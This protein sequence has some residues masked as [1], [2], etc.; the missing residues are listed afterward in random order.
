MGKFDWQKVYVRPF[1]NDENCEIYV[2][3]ANNHT[4]FNKCERNEE[5]FTKILNKL[6]G[7]S[8]EKIP[9]SHSGGYILMNDRRILLIRGW[10][11][12]TGLGGFNLDSDEACEVQDD[13]ANWIVETLNK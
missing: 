9:V 2:R 5:L 13:F 11:R 4:V 1:K 8:N 7:S 3:D 12:L 6:N 10:G